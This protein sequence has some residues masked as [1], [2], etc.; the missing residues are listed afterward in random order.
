MWI[1]YTLYV[2]INIREYIN[3]YIILRH[4]NHVQI[5]KPRG[6]YS[7]RMLNSKFNVNRL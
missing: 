3:C 2:Q 4:F 7:N 1:F 6:I 5:Q